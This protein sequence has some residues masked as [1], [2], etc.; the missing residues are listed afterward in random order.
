MNDFNNKLIKTSSREESIAV[1][2]ILFTHGFTWRSGETIP[3]PDDTYLDNKGNIFYL[4]N[5]LISYDSLSDA[6][7]GNNDIFIDLHKFLMDN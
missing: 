2:L 3:D 6:E 4:R 5:N 1:L 7:I